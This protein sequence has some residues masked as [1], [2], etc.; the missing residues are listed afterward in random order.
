LRYE[1]AL[2]AWRRALALRPGDATIQKRIDN[3]ERKLGK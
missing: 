1:D 2:N 3:L